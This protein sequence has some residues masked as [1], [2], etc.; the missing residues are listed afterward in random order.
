MI[1]RGAEAMLNGQVG[2]LE[3]IAGDGEAVKR[4]YLRV[5]CSSDLVAALRDSCERTLDGVHDNFTFA[6]EGTPYPC[7]PN[8]ERQ[9]LRIG[10]EAHLNAARHARANSI[11]LFLDYRPG[12]IL[13]CE[14]DDG[15]G[16]DVD[17]VR[18]RRNGHLGLITMAERAREAGGDLSINSVIGVGTRIAV[19][20]PASRSGGEVS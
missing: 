13:M 2:K 20:V 8:V 15:C 7:A 5:E 3:S 12:R 4:N 1:A 14:S 9:L 10:H 16:F 17:D 6:V 18:E 11:Q 19:E